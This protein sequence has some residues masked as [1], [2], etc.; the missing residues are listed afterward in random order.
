MARYVT[1]TEARADGYTFEHEADRHEF[2]IRRAGEVLG[3]AHYTLFG[4][5][6][7]AAAIDFDHTEVDPALRGT[8]L[9]GVLAQRALGDEIVRGRRIRTSCWFMEG[10]L[11]KHPEFLVQ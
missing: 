6:T 5:G 1:E 10:Y 4:E 9:S 2:V 8:G 3:V 7:A 11:A